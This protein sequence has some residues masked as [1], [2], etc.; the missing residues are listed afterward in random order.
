MTAAG[1]GS[2]LICQR[3][4]D[5]YRTTR[6]ENSSL[7]T[8]LVTD[9]PARRFQALDVSGPGRWRRSSRGIAWLSANF[10][11]NNPNLAGQTPYYMLYGVERIGA[12]AEKADARPG[13]LVHE[14]GANSSAR[15]RQ[16]DGS[17]H[18]TARRRDEHGLGGAV[19]GQV[20]GQDDPEDHDQEAGRRY[21]AGRAESFPRT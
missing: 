20:D 14:R 1:I 18:S 19:P 16:S 5:R 11:P 12:L 2:L 8:P 17:W 13:R 10:A 21:A 7:L 3:Q 15:R 9:G 6:R 4:L